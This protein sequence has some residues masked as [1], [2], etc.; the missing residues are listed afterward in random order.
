MKVDDI[1]EGHLRVAE[2][3]TVVFGGGIEVLLPTLIHTKR[4]K[5]FESSE[6]LAP[7]DLPRDQRV[8]LQSDLICRKVL[9]H[10]THSN[11]RRQLRTDP[12]KRFGDPS[13]IIRQNKQANDQPL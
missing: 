11:F 1:L 7:P 6:P 10:Q 4:F 12:L 5:L 2:V 13:D 8:A 9:S 3:W